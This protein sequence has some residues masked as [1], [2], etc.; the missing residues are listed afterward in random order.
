MSDIE[1]KIC[2]FHSGCPETHYAGTIQYN[3]EEEHF[4][5]THSGERM[6]HMKACGIPGTPEDVR[7]AC[8]RGDKSYAPKGSAY[9]I[10]FIR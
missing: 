6:S 2:R 9:W 4:V 5:S 3:C 1:M 7:A 10:V 8:E